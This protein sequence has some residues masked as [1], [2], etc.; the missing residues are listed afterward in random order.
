MSALWK[1]GFAL[2]LALLLITPS[3]LSASAAAPV[4]AVSSVQGTA[5]DE[6]AVNVS[7]LGNPG[8]TA[9][10][11]QIS[12]SADDLE[13]LGIDDAGLFADKISTS[14][15]DK[16]PLTI[17]WYASDSANKSD[18]GTLAVLRFRIR[19]GAQS[20]AVTV[21]YNEDNI[22]DNSFGNVYFGAENGLVIVRPK[23]LKGDANGD[24]EVTLLDATLVQRYL[25]NV[26]TDVPFVVL[27][28]ADIDGNGVLESVD[29]TYIQRHL[30]EMEIPYQVG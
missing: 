25:A 15:P 29:V 7:L 27:M 21:S 10:S 2:I 3:V 13:L 12:Y 14:K 18:S 1:K 5:G 30:L 20:S 24:G 19:D 11:I 8:I 4:I 16:N 6:I 23:T 9:L 22:F 17:S 28:N 26:R